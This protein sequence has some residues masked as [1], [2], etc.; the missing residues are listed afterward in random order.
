MA[1]TFRVHPGLASMWFPAAI[2]VLLLL[3]IPGVLLL[4]L[5]LFGLENDVNEWLQA[6][7]NLSYHIPIPR[8][9]SI[10]LVL[11]PF[12]VTLLYF[13]KLKRKPLQVP[14]T[15]LWKKSIEDLHVNSLFQWLRDNVLLLIQLLILLVMIYSV[16]GFQVHAAT[17]SGHY[18]IIMVDNSASMAVSDV[19]T[20]RLEA[21][22]RAAVNEI[23]GHGE[24]D[25]G[26]VIE[27]NSGAKILQPYTTDRNLLRVAVNSIQQTQRTTHVEEALGLADSLANPRTSADDMAVRPA[28]PIPGQERTYVAAEGIAADVHLFSDGRFPD[29]PEFSAGRLNLNYHRIGKAGPDVDNVAIV[30]FNASRDDQTPG[31]VRVF[32]RVVNFRQQPVE[33]KV[34]LEV[35]VKDQGDFKLYDQATKPPTIAARKFSTGDPEKGEPPADVPGDGIATF[36]LN[37]VDETST[38]TLHAQLVGVKDA[39]PLDDEAWLVLGNVRKARI[40]IV[41][42]GNEILRDFFDQDSVAKVATLTYL[43][44]EDLTDEA[45]YRKP[46]RVGAFDLVIFDRC[47]PATVDDLPM[48]NTFFI[49][50]APPPFDWKAMPPLEDT[51]IRNPAS[52]NPLMRHLTALDEI[53]VFEA[54]R[55]PLND[56]RVSP[57]TPRLLET[58]KDTAVLLALSRGSSFTDLVMTFPL[59][60]DKGKW[61]T[62]WNLKLS[63]PV[64]LR[65]VLYTLG[66]VSDTT[67]EDT[68]Q[69]GELKTLRPDA[70]I[71]KMELFAPSALKPVE[72]KKSAQGDFSFKDTERVGVYRAQWAG[73]ERAFAVNLLDPEESNL[74]PRDEVTI[75]STK[76]RADQT[77]GQV[78]D[79]WKWG[80]AGAL[81]LLL[82]EWALYYRRIFI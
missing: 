73:G 61:T 56:P 18:Y 24:G 11:A 45:K 75:G 43:T 2:V 47:A 12:F 49:G 21:A 53:A 67:A 29:V 30:A 39:F 20:S 9:A 3:S 64:F 48:S 46:A 81:A 34:R 16:L 76:L 26:M 78:H 62:T 14:S 70:V 41:T 59:I 7:F 17:G 5:N 65:N 68:I 25:V 23:D 38:L 58:G 10:L 52:K 28:N 35:R 66:N 57:R 33:G 6:K 37:D 1:K 40:A 72:V 80:A 82:L 51:I 15:F 42:S 44:P 32:V 77:K 79:T 71:D 74:Q 27:F 60:N 13:L 36:D 55:F 4:T 22:K 19:G 8:W 69:P 63:F 54:F 50:A 31:K